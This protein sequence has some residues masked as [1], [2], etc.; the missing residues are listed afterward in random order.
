MRVVVQS[1]SPLEAALLR[2][3]IASLLLLAVAVAIK[4]KPP[5]FT[6]VLAM[7][8]TTLLG[9]VMYQLFLGAGLQG[10]PSGAGSVL[11]GL[12]PVITALL[13]SRLLNER[14]SRGVWTGIGISA[15]GALL[16]SISANPQARFEP[17]AVYLLL[18]ALVSSFSTIW[19]KGLLER[20]NFWELTVY[21]TW[22]GAL[23][24]LPLGWSLWGQLPQAQLASTLSAVYLAGFP[25]VLAGLTWTYG[26]T[27]TPAART[28]VWLYLVPPLSFTLGWLWL[29]EV[30]TMLAIVGGVLALVGVVVV[31]RQRTQ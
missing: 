8:P 7:T 19:N 21:T 17:A 13:A 26:L 12:S 27:H 18:A 28:M 4:L 30:P 25:T 9:I 22:L 6:D 16:I 11:V 5:R 31:N 10:V 14:L 29:G 24:L 20:Y 1:Y 2:F 23:F 3:G 15:L